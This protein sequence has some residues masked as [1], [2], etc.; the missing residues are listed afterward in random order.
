MSSEWNESYAAEDPENNLLWRRPYRRLEVEAI[1]DSI[2]AVSGQI[3]RKMYGP[4]MYPYVPSDALD[5]HA[6]KEA[7]RR[8]IYSY[9]KRSLIVPF[10]EVLDLC[11]TTKSTPQRIV[12]SVAPQALTLFNGKFVNRQAEYF[13]KR[14]ETEAGDGS[15]SQ[16]TLAFKLA[17]CREPTATELQ[18]MT[19][20]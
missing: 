3:N 19:D 6:D 9:V 17:L 14:L 20:F 7:N 1:R 8:T 13:A 5:N 18:V 11:D 15:A 12:T 2:L 10:L 4:S 16:I